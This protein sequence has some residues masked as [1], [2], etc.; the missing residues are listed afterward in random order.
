[1]P[2]KTYIPRQLPPKKP[3]RCELCPLIGLIP[4][5]D[6]VKGKRERYY[7]LGCPKPETDENDVPILNEDGTTKW[8]FARLST[9]EVLNV[10]AADRKQKGHL[11]HRPC[12]YIWA[13]WMRLERRHFPM[14]VDTYNRYRLPFEAEQQQKQQPKFSFE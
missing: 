3:D 14:V 8:T 4:K 10:S 2:K 6:R 5:E 13:A 11:L 12:D 1:M 7:C 9:R